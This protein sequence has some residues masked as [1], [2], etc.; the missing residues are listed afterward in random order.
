MIE[1]AGRTWGIANA[2]YL[3]VI[4]SESHLYIGET[5]DLPPKRWGQHLSSGGTFTG[6][7]QLAGLDLPGTTEILFVGVRCTVIDSVDKMSQKRAR[8]AV[9]E[10]LH[11]QFSLNA[12]MLGTEFT[13]LSQPPPAPVRFTWSFDL[14]AVARQIRAH[15]ANEFGAWKAKSQIPVHFDG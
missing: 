13:I 5:G 15:V 9:E 8:R 7:T 12:R 1:A 3:Y 4:I 11:R 10:E 14:V 2:S 6:K